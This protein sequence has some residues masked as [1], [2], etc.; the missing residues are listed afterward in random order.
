MTF[1]ELLLA[2]PDLNEYVKYMPDRIRHNH[3]IK[4]LPPKY[5]VH[6]KDSVLQSF[7]IVCRGE[8]RV[9][10]EFE[11]GNIFMIEKNEAISFIGEV[12]ILAEEERTSVTIET[13]TECLVMFMSI[14]DFEYWIERDIHFLRLV[15]RKIAKKLYRSSYN[16]GARFFYSAP[17]LLLKHIIDYAGGADI[18][19]N[20]KIVLR[21][22]RNQLNEELGMT[23]KTLNRTIARLKDEG[24]ISVEKGKIAMTWAQ[25][26]RAVEE[27][28]MYMNKNKRQYV[29]VG[30]APS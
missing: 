25:Y 10:N 21:R 5:I 1:E 9:I 8:H 26:E 4:T 17:Y 13:L 23:V 18:A 30:G 27:A 24:L 14:E 6:Q 20:G 7:G 2:A 3:T 19:K 12:T 28:G 15:S 16:Q 29:S 11:N 22:T